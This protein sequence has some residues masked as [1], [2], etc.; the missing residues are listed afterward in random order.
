MMAKKK[1]A[2]DYCRDFQPLSA[3]NVGYRLAVDKDFTDSFI[4]LFPKEQKSIARRLGY[5]ALGM[6]S[7]ELSYHTP[8]HVLS[9]LQF[10]K[11]NKIELTIPQKL[12]IFYH[13]VIY[14]V[15]NKN[16]EELSADFARVCLDP[17]INE[18][19][20]SYIC[21]GIIYTSSHL[22]DNLET[23]KYDLI[24]DL[25]LHSFALPEE[26]FLKQNSCVEKEFLDSGIPKEQWEDGR[27]KFL[28]MLYQK[29][30]FFRTK[31]FR[32]KFEKQA[33]DNIKKLIDSL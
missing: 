31:F 21:E 10:A 13:D 22:E 3:I 20:L 19:N 6:H 2:I 27:K 8:V 29:D 18:L 25:D 24:M 7:T 23:D 5:V 14:I 30:N 17:Y 4:E 12:C 28:E 11:E 1:E 32:D 9:I 33:K 15:G 16:N 26:Y